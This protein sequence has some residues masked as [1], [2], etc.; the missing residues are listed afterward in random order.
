MPRYRVTI[1]EFARIIARLS[2]E[3]EKAVIRGLQSAALRLEGIVV[4][5]IDNAEPDPAVD[6]GEL[7]NSH[8]MTRTS[9]GARVE[10]T[11]PH[12]A[13]IEYGTRPFFPPTEP[14]ARWALRK[15]IADDEEEAEEI[16]YAIALKISVDGIFPRAYM[17]KSVDRLITDRILSEEIN[18][19]LA[20]VRP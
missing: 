16:A 18:R 6:R 1:D 4:E 10:M 5:E 9:R 17:A 14:L 20:K 12:A 13:A 11:A 15:G 19:E 7:R 2:P 3:L 8:R